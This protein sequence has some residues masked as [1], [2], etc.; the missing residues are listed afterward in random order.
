MLSS[1]HGFTLFQLILIVIGL[2]ITIWFLI[3]IS[4]GSKVFNANDGTSFNSK[5]ECIKY[6]KVSNKINDF[7]QK[8]LNDPK[9]QDE[10][11]FKLEF[12]RL[13]KEKGFPNSKALW[14]YRDQFKLLSELFD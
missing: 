2:L 6:E 8:D 3:L 5:E 4:Q 12:I 13:L 14:K 1:F 7:Y 11:E 10:I 9:T